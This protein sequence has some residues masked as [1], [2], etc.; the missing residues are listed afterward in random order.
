MIINFVCVVWAHNQAGEI[1]KK[2][3]INVT[4]L[5]LMRPDE[6]ESINIGWS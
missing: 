2:C 4:T 6:E 3:K 1:C 5:T